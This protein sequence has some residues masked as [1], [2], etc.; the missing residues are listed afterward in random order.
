MKFIR[1]AAAA[2]ALGALMLG[3]QPS[4]AGKADDTLHIVWKE[5]VP[6]IDP[7]FNQL[8]SGYII[9]SLAMDTLILK[10]PDT[11]KFEPLLATS[12]E[13]IDNTT[14]RFKLRD[15]VKF[16]NGEVFDADDV[17]YTLNFIADS[18]NH[19]LLPNLGFIKGAKKVDPL[20]VDVELKNPFPAALEYFASIIAIYP[21]EYHSKVGPEGMGKHLVGTG[22]YIVKEIDGISHYL[23][24]RNENYFA[25]GAKGK[26][27]IGKID[28][29]VVNDESTE[30]LE[31]MSGKADWIWKFNADQ[32]P[33]LQAQPNV[34]AN[35]YE[36][37]RTGF[38]NLNIVGDGTSK[39]N[40]LAKVK[41]RQAIAHAIN[42]EELVKYLVQGEARVL[43][44]PC[45]PTQWGCDE[46]AAVKYDYDP[47]KA[48]E[49]LKEAGYPNGF[50]TQVI[51]ARNAQWVAKVQEDL[52]KVGIDAKGSVIQGATLVDL[53]G[54]GQVP[55][56]YWDWGSYSI[57]DAAAVLPAFFG[58]QSSSDRTGD[59]EVAGLVMKANEELDT[60]KR[61][62]LYDQAI[63]L[64]T[65]RALQIPLHSF[66]VPYAFI[67]ELD[68]KAYP[69]EMPRFYWAK[70]K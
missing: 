28:I 8:R 57:M 5:S 64:I 66:V 31:F 70:W 17:V 49:L 30:L 43:D 62:A 60:E 21:N 59:K 13:W 36:S 45:F 53:F 23:L 51:G 44:V 52:T 58:G 37:M 22:P 25:D 4:N 2:V 39:D 54:Q 46:D 38:L 15:G 20:T 18:S 10:N 1:L 16:H 55:I 61:K 56:G 9:A 68:F 32:V 69:D 24:V 19:I 12:W 34:T 35:L 7:Y 26:P 14:L 67:N 65:E 48:K 63:K 6:N 29:R 11:G 41:V 50:S 3:A 40:P 42:K 33:L 27:A 47:E